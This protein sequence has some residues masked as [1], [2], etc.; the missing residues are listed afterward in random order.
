MRSRAGAEHLKVVTRSFDAAY[1]NDLANDPQIRPF[2]GSPESGP[3]DLTAL[4][5]NPQNICLTAEAGGWMLF[6]LMP[7]AYELHTLFR[8]TGRGKKF[9]MAAREALR[10][11]FT[12][13]DAL[14]ILTKCPEDN[15]GARMAAIL[16]GFRERFRREN[17]WDGNVAISYQALTIDDWFVRDPEC[18]A[19]GDRVGREIDS[20]RLAAGWEM[21]P[22]RDDASNYALG[23]A[24]LMLLGAQ[25]DKAVGFYNRWAVFAGRETIVAL[26]AAMLDI[27]G[28]IA[29]NVNG[30]LRLLPR[31]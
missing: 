7:G 11:V 19:M 2:I 20:A 3:L 24:L 18:W 21:P 29:E 1:F 23:A 12:H 16:A 6:K 8:P 14:E 17:V 13:T 30:H 15:P 22:P 4:V 5:E 27:Q 10:L 25:P 31:T 28:A 9:F 26:S